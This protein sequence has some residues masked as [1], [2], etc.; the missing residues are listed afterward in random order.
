MENPI[1]ATIV[2][3]A[4]GSEVTGI[5]G[6]V[7]MVCSVSGLKNPSDA[8]FIFSVEGECS[9]ED[10]FNF[11]VNSLIQMVTINPKTALMFSLRSG[12]I[13]SIISEATE[14]YLGNEACAG[15][16]DLLETLEALISRT[17]Q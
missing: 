16:T 17:C 10:Y 11:V 12:S 13:E 2:N 7:V 3:R 5:N 15:N 8:N 1:R 6:D 9:G 14:E 4:D